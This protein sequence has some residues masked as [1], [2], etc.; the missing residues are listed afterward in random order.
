MDQLK[1]E[2]AREVLKDDAKK[3]TALIENQKH[4]CVSCPAFEEVIDT[5]MFGFSKKVEFAISMNMIEEEEGQLM[6][7]T[8][9]KHLNDVYSNAFE[10]NKNN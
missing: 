2:L 9:E 7:S 4:L 10:Q 1:N 8:L 5:Q 6:L 3:I